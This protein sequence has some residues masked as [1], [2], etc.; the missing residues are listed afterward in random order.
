MGLQPE[1]GHDLIDGQA[2]ALR[3]AAQGMDIA[4]LK[5]RIESFLD[6]GTGLEELFQLS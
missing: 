5:A 4:P 2:R 1:A 6:A 3:R